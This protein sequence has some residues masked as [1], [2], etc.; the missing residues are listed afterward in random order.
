MQFDNEWCR[1]EGFERA[2]KEECKFALAVIVCI[3][4]WAGAIYGLYYWF[5]VGF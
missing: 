4:I 2:P 1:N 5:T 3:G